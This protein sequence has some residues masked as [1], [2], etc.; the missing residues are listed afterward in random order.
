[1]KINTTRFGEVEVEESKIISFPLGIPGFPQLKRYF[2]FDYK[3]EIKWLHA[4][5]DP[6]IAFVVTDPF[7]FF[8]DYSIEIADDVKEFLGIE[9]ITNVVILIM[10]TINDSGLNANLKAPIIINVSNFRGT[11]VIL[12]TDNYSFRV[13]L[14]ALAMANTGN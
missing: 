14:T 10:L 7:N 2:L 9:D 13:P 8:P 6:D 1:M 3:D 11:Q 5:D 12:D 4:T